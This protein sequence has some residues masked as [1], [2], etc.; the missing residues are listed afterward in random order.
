[1]CLEKYT[2]SRFQW[3]D[4]TVRVSGGVGDAYILKDSS[5]TLRY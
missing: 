3:P 1:M 4:L 5:W 2:A